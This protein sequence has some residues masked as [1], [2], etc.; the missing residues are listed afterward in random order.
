MTEAV[1]FCDSDRKIDYITCHNC[2]RKSR[3]KMRVLE[4]IVLAGVSVLCLTVGGT[5]A[6]ESPLFEYSAM[7][8]NCR[9][10]MNAARSKA[11]LAKFGEPGV[12]DKLNIT[13]IVDYVPSPAGAVPS[14][15]VPDNAEARSHQTKDSF[16]ESVCMAV[17]SGNGAPPQQGKQAT[18]TYM[19][20]PQ[21]S[22]TDMCEE[23]VEFWSGAVN[24]FPTLPPAYT[25]NEDLYKNER[26]V[27][28]VGLY[29]PNASAT[30]D[31]AIITC[32][33]KGDDDENE[34]SEKLNRKR[35]VKPVASAVDREKEASVA[36]Q[37]PEV[38]R[39][40]RG[41]AAIVE[42]APP[43]AVP[44]DEEPREFESGPGINLEEEGA[45]PENTR[46]LSDRPNTVYSL[47]CLSRPP[48]LK[49]NQMPFT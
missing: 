47:L 46:R 10:A 38:T 22:P 8:V 25:P 40:G 4:F 24:K 29:N 42:A 30:V 33:R 3:G 13:K 18:G 44:A 27:S 26:N 21:G 2:I 5:E 45:R 41:E 35:S 28:F 20:A 1:H 48:A 11:G 15:K 12:E 32:E 49:E 37:S 36:D 6:A 19:Y 43:N 7:R 23:A 16:L 9:S 31:C 14:S 34:E 39:R 17:M